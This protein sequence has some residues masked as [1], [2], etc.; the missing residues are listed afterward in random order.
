MLGPAVGG[1]LLTAQTSGD[2]LSG[3]PITAAGVNRASAAV[4]SVFVDRSVPQ[5]TVDAG[6]F[7]AYLMARL[8]VTPLPPD[9]GLRVAVD[10]SLLRLG[11]RLADLPSEARRQLSRLT[12][13]VPLDTRIEAR[14]GL[15]RAGRDGMRFHLQGI[16][17][18][19]VP[20]PEL[21]VDPVFRGI[22]SRYPALTDTGRDLLVTLPEGGTMRLVRGGVFLKG[23]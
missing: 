14:V 6:D 13:L 12:L 9:L 10:D 22:G 18:G 17:L 8:G 7:T 11:G 2:S 3:R 15:L 23:P 5:T 1:A 19:G 21:F 16:S 20:V 4:D